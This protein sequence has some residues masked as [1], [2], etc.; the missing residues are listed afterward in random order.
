VQRHTFA[1]VPGLI[2][3]PDHFAP[4]TCARIVAHALNL[5]DR[6]EAAVSGGIAPET[7]HIPQPAYVRS[8]AHNLQSEEQFVRVPLEEAGAR[9]IRGEYF[10]RYGEDGHALAYFQRNANLPDFVS[11]ELLP[12]VLE[13][14]ESEGLVAPC[15]DLTWKLTAN[16]YRRTN[17]AVAGFP[18]HVDIPTN[19]IVTMI[20]NVQRAARFEIAKGEVREALD[21]PVG[22]LLL[23]SGE[24]RYEWMHRVLPSAEPRADSA[25][26]AVERVSLVLGY[27]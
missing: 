20:L 2:F 27:Q 1:H 8:A 11:A 10:P 12:G 25:A 26:H 23:L 16:F 15:A 22:A 24:S 4:S 17:G 21:M 7:A 3:R 5:Y 19:G 6:L 9:T 14:I 18:F 13:V